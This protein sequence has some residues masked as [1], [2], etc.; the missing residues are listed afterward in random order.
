M[1]VAGWLSVCFALLA[2][3]CVMAGCVGALLI[4]LRQWA[5]ERLRGMLLDTSHDENH[6]KTSVPRRDF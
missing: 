6:G 1:A 4:Y 3:L 5:V 2:I